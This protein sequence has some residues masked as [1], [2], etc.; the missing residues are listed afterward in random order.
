MN[1]INLSYNYLTFESIEPYINQIENFYYGSQEFIGEDVI[2]LI[3]VGEPL[4]ISV[5][6]GGEFNEY[7]WYLWGTP[8]PGADSSHYTLNSISYSE[9]GIYFCVITNSLA[10]QLTLVSYDFHVGDVYG[11]RDQK[12]QM[13]VSI[14]PNPANNILYISKPND[15]NLEEIRF[16]NQKGNEVLRI[17]PLSN[18]LNI[19]ELIPGF[20]TLEIISE[21]WITRT[22]LIKN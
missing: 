5:D 11:L 17:K 18:V 8:I 12:M 9:F 7:Q 3:Q 4:D 14:F 15:L 6:I 19:S 20:Y 1:E 13:D 16:Y 2:I 10:T 22:K 21:N